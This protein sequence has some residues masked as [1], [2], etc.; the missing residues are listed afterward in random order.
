[1][2]ISTLSSPSTIRV[3]VSSRFLDNFH[4]PHHS[5]SVLSPTT[6]LF[7]RHQFDYCR[8]LILRRTMAGGSNMQIFMVSAL[9][10][11]EPHNFGCWMLGHCLFARRTFK[12]LYRHAPT[13]RHIHH[14]MQ[15]PLSSS[16]NIRIEKLKEV[17]T[18][19]HV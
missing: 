19:K 10:F 13:T 5:H 2:R 14:F 16:R 11:M 12:V 1:M 18:H 8:I 15:I 6:S 7:H 4:F 17:H 3:K 9:L